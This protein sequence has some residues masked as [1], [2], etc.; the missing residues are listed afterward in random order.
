MVPSDQPSM[1]RLD[2]S[3]LAVDLQ[4]VLDIAAEQAPARI[5]DSLKASQ[6]PNSAR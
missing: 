5:L 4:T 2:A 3:P 6:G 1:E